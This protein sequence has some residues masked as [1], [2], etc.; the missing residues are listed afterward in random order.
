MFDFQDSGTM[1]GIFNLI[2]GQLRMPIFNITSK[3]RSHG[4]RGA[5]KMLIFSA[6]KKLIFNKYIKL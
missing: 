5:L 3:D 1:K 2:L 4:L 6:I